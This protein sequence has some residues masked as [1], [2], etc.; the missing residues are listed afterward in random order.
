[1]VCSELTSNILLI[2]STEPR[3][4]SPN[5]PRAGKRCPERFYNLSHDKGMAPPTLNQSLDSHGSGALGVPTA[6][7]GTAV[8][9]DVSRQ[10]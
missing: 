8:H 7:S 10:M 9:G 4:G 2:R 5:L 1:M 3:P 6:R